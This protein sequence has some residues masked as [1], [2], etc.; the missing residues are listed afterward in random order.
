MSVNKYTPAIL[1]SILLCVVLAILYPH[2]RYYIDPDGVAYLT[3]A[4][5]YASGDYITAIN[6]YW[7]PWSCWLTTV[8]IKMGCEA[9]PSSVIVNAAGAIGFLLVSQSL[10]QKFGIEKVLQWVLNFTLVVFLSYAVYWQSFDDL[11][12]CFFLLLSLRILLSEKFQSNPFLWV[13]MG[14]TGACAYFAKSYCFPFFILNTVC[15]TM[16]LTNG[17][18]KQ[19]MKIS[20]TAIGTM[21]L[22]SLPWLMLLHSKYGTWTT[23]TAGSLNLSWYL[24]GHPYWKEGIRFLIPPA[25]ANSPDYWEDPYLANAATPHFWNSFHLLGLQMLRLVLNC[26]KLLVSMIQVSV[27][28][29]AILGFAFTKVLL[30]RARV[31]YP[32]P[33]LILTFSFLLFPLGYLLVNF[34]SR[35]IWYMLPLSMILWIHASSEK[36]FERFKNVTYI[37]LLSFII[38]PVYGLSLNFNEGTEEYQLAQK[39]KDAHIQGSFTSNRHPRYMGRLAYFSGNQYYYNILP[40]LRKNKTDTLNASNNVTSLF[41]E[42]CRD[43][44]KYYFHFTGKTDDYFPN[45]SSAILKMD[46]SGTKFIQKINDLEIYQFME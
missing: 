28:F 27:F 22:C 14:I 12:E 34:E 26:Y 35:Y 11:W 17:N 33:V 18:L 2:Y 20:L 6:G 40:N 39:L 19:C 42:A 31:N 38:Y 23:S 41:R 29:P 9:I 16:L 37:A 10:F 13:A 15:C 25:Y 46:S 43:K 44:V 5:R 24:V 32:K 36:G 45:C 8:L 21:L 4:Q 30:K 7:S 1:G 3:I